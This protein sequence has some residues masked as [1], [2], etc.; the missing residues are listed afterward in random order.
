MR[1]S[2]ES[3]PAKFEATEEV[4]NT[5]PDTDPV[6]AAPRA[7]THRATTVEANTIAVER[8]IG[9]MKVHLAGPLDLDQL[10]H[11]AGL[12]RF[13]LVRVFDELTGTTPHHFLACLRMQRAKDLLLAPNASITEVCM[14]VGYTSLGTFSKTFSTL[15]GISP[16]EFR[17]MS[18]SL[19]VKQ[20]A[21]AVR[22]F[23]HV[24]RHV[25]GLHLEGV[26]ERS[27]KR[28]GFIF[29]GTF[30]H[31]VPQEAP[32]SGTVLLRPGAFRIERPPIPEFHLLAALI[33]FTAKW[34]TMAANL[35]VALVGG[36]RVQNPDPTAP[37]QPRL[38]LRP[39]RLTDPPIVLALPPLLR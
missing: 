25:P 35:P 2:Q 26:V 34:S 23:L 6:S 20:L 16:Q 32:L 3:R 9:H 37:L 13:H 33:P 24:D 19:T 21:L 15:V 38:R 12:S 5:T 10:A 27:T 39:V 36:L 17:A 1:R 4:R 8:A 28:Q 7:V 18:K 31:G 29:V 11:I 30:R 14:E 22:R